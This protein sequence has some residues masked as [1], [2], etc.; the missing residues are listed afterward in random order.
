WELAFIA[1]PEALARGSHVTVLLA[2]LA[3]SAIA[4]GL[5]SSWRMIVRLRRDVAAAQSV[6]QYTLLEKLGEGGMG[7]VYK[8]RHALLRRPTAVKVLQPARAGD[9]DFKRF[10]REVQL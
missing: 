9:V 7:A 2:G 1:A 4:A 5:L 8:A 6:G 3:L 10:E